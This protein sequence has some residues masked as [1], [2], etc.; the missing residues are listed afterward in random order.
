MLYKCPKC[1]GNLNTAF[2]CL[3]CGKTFQPSTYDS[4]GRWDVKY[5]VEKAQTIVTQESNKER[6]FA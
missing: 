6:V 4:S 3:L 5:L 2:I 1:G